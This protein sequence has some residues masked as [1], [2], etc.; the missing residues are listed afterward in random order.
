MTFFPLAAVILI[1][2]R[3]PPVFL[4]C[5]RALAKAGADVAL[6]NGK[7]EDAVQ[8]SLGHSFATLLLA[9]PK[10]RTLAT[11]KMLLERIPT[12]CRSFTAIK[13]DIKAALE[14]VETHNLATLLESFFDL[15]LQAPNTSK[16]A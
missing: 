8:L 3:P 6:V 4:R 1:R 13:A 5:F 14:L 9:F 7:G 15:T 2:F 11:Q 12:V 16:S 10:A